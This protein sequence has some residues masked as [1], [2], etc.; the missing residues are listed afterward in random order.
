M[1]IKVSRCG[2]LP[3]LTDHRDRL[4]AVQVEMIGTLPAR[5]DLRSQCPPVISGQFVPLPEHKPIGLNL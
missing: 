3:D 5:C 1:R 2:R 4:D